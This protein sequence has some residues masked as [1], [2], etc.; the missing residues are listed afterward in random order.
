MIEQETREKVRKALKGIFFL[1][2]GVLMGL[3]WYGRREETV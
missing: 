2:F 1:G 3:R